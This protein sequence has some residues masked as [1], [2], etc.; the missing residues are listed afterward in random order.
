VKHDDNQNKKVIPSAP[1]HGGAIVTRV[2][3][4]INSHKVL[5]TVPLLDCVAKDDAGIV[6]PDLACGSGT[7]APSSHFERSSARMGSPFPTQPYV[8][9]ANDGVFQDEFI[10]WMKYQFTTPKINTNVFFELDNEPDNWDGDAH[11]A[12]HSNAVT[13]DEVIK[14]DTVYANM[15]KEQVPTALVFG[16]VLSGW[17]GIDKWGGGSEAF[18]EVYLKAMKQAEANEGRRLIDVLDVHWYPETRFYID[19]D[20]DGS[21]DQDEDTNHDGILTPEEDADNDGVLDNEPEYRIMDDESTVQPPGTTAA[22]RASLIAQ[23]KQKR[24]QSPRALWDA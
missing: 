4:Q 20:N 15:I 19:T 13:Y 11:H 23:M 6:A 12:V 14:K 10:N 8:P 21:R 5:I 7:G 18:V 9:G 1:G 17:R 24:V 2:T 22:Q 3:A 16:P